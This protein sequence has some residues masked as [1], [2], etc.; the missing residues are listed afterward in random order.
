MG[1]AVGEERRRLF[2]DDPDAVELGVLV[3]ASAPPT[4]SLPDLTW[5]HF[6]AT[7]R[8]FLAVSSEAEIADPGR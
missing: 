8:H 4:Q 1:V 5:S 2:F 7:A 3:E 6:L